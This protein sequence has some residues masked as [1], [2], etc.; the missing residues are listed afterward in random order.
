MKTDPELVHVP[1]MFLPVCFLLHLSRTNSSALHSQCILPPHIRP[2]SSIHPHASSSPERERAG[3]SF[4]RFHRYPLD[5]LITQS[6]FS[7]SLISDSILLLLHRTVSFI[8]HLHLIF[9]TH[10]HRQ[11]ERETESICVLVMASSQPSP[12]KP[13]E[14]STAAAEAA[15][16]TGPKPWEGAYICILLLLFYVED[17]EWRCMRCACVC[18]V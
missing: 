6:I 7:F 1:L 9:N 16:N 12:S 4:T 15:S 11:R 8:L 2:S 17:V 3:I 13:W 14:R 5:L 10:T 18:C